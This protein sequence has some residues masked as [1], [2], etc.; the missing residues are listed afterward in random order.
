MTPGANRLSLFDIGSSVLYSE[1]QCAP[2]QLRSPRVMAEC[3][4]MLRGPADLFFLA[5]P[6][7]FWPVAGGLYVSP[8]LP[9]VA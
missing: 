4:C 1:A 3:P 2:V 9:V 8:L 6:G 5:C 7:V